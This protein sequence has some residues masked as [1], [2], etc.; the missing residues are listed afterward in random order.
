VTGSVYGG[1]VVEYSWDNGESWS[2][3]VPIT[4]A[5]HIRWLVDQLQ[6]GETKSAGFAARVESSLPPN[7]TIQNAGYITS[8]QTAVFFGDWIPSN[9][10]LVKTEVIPPLP[11]L[12]IEKQGSSSVV[13]P[14][15]TL[16]Y[17]L[18]VSNEGGTARGLIVSDT[19][20]ND[21]SYVSCAGTLCSL[22]TGSVVWGPTDLPGAGSVLSLTLV[23]ATDPALVNGS[24]IRNLTYGV[25]ADNAP[26]IRG[27]PVTTTVSIAELDVLKWGVPS[28]AF[29]G[30]RI[31][32]GIWVTNAGGRARQ[33][34]VSDTLPTDTSY[35]GCDCAMSGFSGNVDRSID[36]ILTCG[37]GFECM[38]DAGSVFW[39]LPEIPPERS[40]LMTFWVTVSPSLTDG[41]LI[42][43]RR[44]GASA[45]G[46]LP[47]TGK[48]PVTITVQT[49]RLGIEKVVNPNPVLVGNELVYT[50]TLQNDGN[51]LRNV[52]VTDL[53]PD[54]V[55]YVD[56][57]PPALTGLQCELQGVDQR[58]VVWWLQELAAHTQ[59]ELFLTV[60]VEDGAGSTIV[61]RTYSAWIPDAGREV[62]GSPVSVSVA[63]GRLYLP[64]LLR[65]FP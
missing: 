47:V 64:V 14:D 56:C 31:D 54:E 3:S 45:E 27:E 6:P 33:V 55:S 43:N 2:S 9:E 48:Q 24:L 23:V 30:S 52:E 63:G 59:Q 10:V 53:L 15:D 12:S 58:S 17:T 38:P 25:V 11:I 65:T 13:A 28:H 61:N 44:Y 36:G 39:F 19:I 50:I 18:R 26:L 29:A 57:G 16:T 37:A 35:G 1:D 60:Q 5:T 41:H 46:L 4:P 7:T 32:Y 49:L 42:V 20:P 21:V 51:P 22:D 62:S 40:L 34:V 8:A